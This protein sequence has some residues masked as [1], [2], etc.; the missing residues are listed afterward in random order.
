MAD[1]KKVRVGNTP[2]V[3]EVPKSTLPGGREEGLKEPGLRDANTVGSK[4]TGKGPRQ[5]NTPH[6]DADIDSADSKQRHTTGGGQVEFTSENWP[7]RENAVQTGETFSGNGG[8]FP[9]QTSQENASN[10][11]QRSRIARQEVQDAE[12]KALSDKRFKNEKDQ[13]KVSETLGKDV[14]NPRN[15]R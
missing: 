5:G 2:H 7:A 9:F 11:T 13:R 6:T 14:T 15:Q 10:Y 1:V 4:P 3:G 12:I 8:Q